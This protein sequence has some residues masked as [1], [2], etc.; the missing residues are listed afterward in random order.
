MMQRRVPAISGRGGKTAFLVSSPRGV[1][2]KG[3]AVFPSPALKLQGLV[4][5]ALIM[6]F[7]LIVILVLVLLVLLALLALLPDYRRYRRLKSM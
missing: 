7:W 2:Q 5:R 3:G 6:N 1:E 4:Y